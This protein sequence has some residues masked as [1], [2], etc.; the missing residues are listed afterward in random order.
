M[1]SK[2]AQFFADLTGND[3]LISIVFKIITKGYKPGIY[4][5]LLDKYLTKN[6]KR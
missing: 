6:E 4:Y 5:K 2:I 3:P 1:K